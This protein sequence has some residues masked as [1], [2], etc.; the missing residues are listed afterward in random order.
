MGPVII[1]SGPPGSGKSTQAKKVARYFG[2]RYYSAGRLFREIARERGVSLEE[3]SII[4]SRDPSIDL[5]I[6]RRSYE[7]ARKGGVVIDGHL[8]GWVVDMDNV[9]KILVVAPLEV[10]VRRI[11][12]RDNKRLD[13]A[14]RETVIREYYQVKRFMEY[15]GFDP[16]DYSLYDLVVNTEKSSIETVFETI[17][18]FLEKIFK[19][20]TNS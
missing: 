15:Y 5:E 12:M 9:V 19:N 16:Y 20:Q 17:K 11:A 18:V 2:L 1:F 13:E 10:R 14:L 6:D 8:T 3:L 4:A 7:V